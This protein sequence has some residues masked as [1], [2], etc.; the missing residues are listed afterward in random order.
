[1]YDP[2]SLT[3][4]LGYAETHYRFPFCPSLLFRRVPEIY[5]DAP[6]RL[7]PSSPLPF[8]LVVKDADRFPLMISRITAAVAFMD[9][10]RIFTREF[11]FSDPEI[12]VPLFTRLFHLPLPENYQGEI[13]LNIK[14]EGTCRKRPLLVL[15]DNLPFGA[16]FSFP[17]H[18]ADK[19]LPALPG[20]YYGEPHCHSSYTCDEVEF[21]APLEVIGEMA[22]AIGL[23]WVF[24]TDHSYDLDAKNPFGSGQ[25][26]FH[27]MRE[28]ATRHSRAACCLVPGEEIS[29]QNKMNKTVHLVQINSPEFIEGY[30]DSGRERLRAC[31]HTLAQVA[32][33]NTEKEGTFLFAAHPGDIPGFLQNLL[34]NRGHWTHTD[35]QAGI[36]ASQF[37]N[38][39][40][41]RSFYRG[42]AQ[43]IQLLLSGKKIAPLG[44]NDAHGD[45]SR[46]RKIALP[47]FSIQEEKNVGFGRVRTALQ[48]ETLSPEKIVEA[49]RAC[50]TVVTNGPFIT[51]SIHT[52]RGVAGLGETAVGTTLTLHLEALST[53]EFGPLKQVTLYQGTLHEKENKIAEWAVLPSSPFRFTAVHPVILLF[54]AYFRVEVSSKR[55]NDVFFGLS[56]PIWAET[57]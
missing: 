51:F 49:V 24:V 56:S 14:L 48:T 53:E 13:Q 38:G 31:T 42:R 41:D 22:A 45:F 32:E 25:N 8:V 20:Y 23:S 12:R 16:H 55:S 57:A 17:V 21:G 30:G 27:D 35:F 36:S 33:K 43:W 11:T 18:V 50:R 10:R 5:F 52:P 40:R 26:S 4:I 6:H 37:W 29:V 46:V 39:K 9:T 7:N 2:L 34:L 3:F 19:P 28:A 54:P 1:M 47:F 44:G 15:N